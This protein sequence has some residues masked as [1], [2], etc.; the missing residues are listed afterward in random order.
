M[1]ILNTIL[2]YLRDI[3]IISI[4]LRLLL[5][6]LFG[7]TIGLERRKQGR[8]AGMRT[9][10]FVCLG[11]ALAGTVGFYSVQVLGITGDPLRVAAQVISGIGFLGVGTILLKG[12]F[13]ITGLTTAAGLWCAA[14][15]GISLGAGF[16]EGSIIAFICS[17]LTITLL[18]RLE[19]YF[20]KKNR[21]ISI[22]I[23]LNSDN[24]VRHVLDLLEKNYDIGSLE[25]TAP[26]SSTAGNV[27]LEVSV[28]N[29]SFD[30]SPRELIKFL[31]AE[32]C[33]VFALE[34]I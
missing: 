19:K 10:I 22:Y 7:G 20:N 14:A 18:A 6:M 11:S 25:V 29:R 12:K 8:A 26:R 15:I 32:E 1:E 5:A 17:L 31:E 21:R 3:N 30:I 28:R 2:D 24:Q 23:E 4:T 16:Y 34:A 27:G 9:Y 33:V 13:H